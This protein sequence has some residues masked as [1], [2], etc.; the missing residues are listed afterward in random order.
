MRRGPAAD[1]VTWAGFLDVV[2]RGL[3]LSTQAVYSR[4]T[5]RD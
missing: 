4:G 2:L 3:I 1:R 5:P